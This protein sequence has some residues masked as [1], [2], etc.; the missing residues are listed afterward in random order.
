MKCD[1]DS[2]H[3]CENTFICLGH[4]LAAELSCCPLL[5]GCEIISDQYDVTVDS[6]WCKEVYHVGCPAEV[7]IKNI[8]TNIDMDSDDIRA[9]RAAGGVVVAGPREPLIVHP[10]VMRLSDYLLLNMKSRRI[11]FKCLEYDLANASPQ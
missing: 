3:I 9:I 7:T 1:V 8:K 6:G 4:N 2:K 5:Y 11:I 10:V